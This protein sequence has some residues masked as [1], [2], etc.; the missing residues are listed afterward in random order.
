MP[1]PVVCVTQRPPVVG[2]PPTCSIHNP[3]RELQDLAH[4]SLIPWILRGLVDNDGE[5][6]EHPRTSSLARWIIAPGN[7]GSAV[8]DGL[9]IAEEREV[10]ASGNLPGAA[11][12]PT[13]ALC[14]S[15]TASQSS[16]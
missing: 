12:D 5:A 15:L 3:S 13:C 16:A 1:L 2:D 8:V 10:T 6:C 4:R 7:P 9:E 14:H 11:D